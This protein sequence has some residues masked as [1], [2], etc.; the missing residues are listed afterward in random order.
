MDDTVSFPS[1]LLIQS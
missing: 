1:K